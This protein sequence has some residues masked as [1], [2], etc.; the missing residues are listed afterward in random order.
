MRPVFDLSNGAKCSN[1]SASAATSGNDETKNREMRKVF[2]FFYGA[3][4]SN[5]ISSIS[6]SNMQEKDVKADPN[7]D[8]DST[9]GRVT[10][11]E[12]K[13]CIPGEVVEPKKKYVSMW[14]LIHRHMASDASAESEN[15]PSTGANDEENQHDGDDAKRSEIQIRQ[16]STKTLEQPQKWILLQRFVKELEKVTK[17]NPRKPRYLRLNP[18]PEA[19]KVNL[20]TQTADERKR[21]EEW[22]LDYA[23]QLAI[24][25]LGPTQKRKV[26]LLIKAFETVVPPQGDNSQIAFPKLRASNEKEFVPTEGNMGCKAEKVIAGIDGKHEENDGSMYKNHE[27]QQPDE[28]TSA[29]NDKDLVEGHAWKEDSSKDSKEEI[30]PGISSLTDEVDG[31]LEISTSANDAAM[32]ENVAMEET[33]KECEKTHKHVRG[34]SILLSMSDPKE[35]DGG[36]KGKAHKRSYISM[37]HMI[38]QLVLL[39]SDVA[40]KVGNDYLMELMMR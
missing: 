6:A 14:S 26:E 35:D 25:Q 37:W 23:L 11:S 36:S 15:K 22:M 10:D 40:S 19:E 33:A 39:L 1:D 9:S 27:T 20:T 7:E 24:S 28:M 31:A 12:S 32:Q 38:S 2:D 4:C 16:E 21:G 34:F 8:L 3:K 13:S 29:S 17:I 5:E 18:D 30:S